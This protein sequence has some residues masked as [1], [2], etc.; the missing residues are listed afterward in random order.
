[1]I[2]AARELSKFFDVKGVKN[3]KIRAVENV[4]I[5]IKEGEIVGLVGESGSGKSTLGRLLIRLIEPTSGEILYNIPDDE[6]DEFDNALKSNDR[7]AI[8]KIANKYSIMRLHGKELKTF[9]RNVGIV[10]QDPYSSLDPRM[11]IE[12][13]IAEPIVE[14]GYLNGEKVKER[15]LE[16][17][18]EVQLPR[19]FSFRYPHELSGGQRQRIALARGIATNPKLVIL[20]EPTSALDVSIQAEILELLKGLRK[21]YNMAMLLITHNISVISYMA[22]RVFV[23][24]AGKIMEKGNKIDIIKNPEHPYTQALIS[25]VPQIK[26]VKAR[27]ILKGDPPNLINPPKG[28]RFHPRCPV[29]L[30]VCGWTADEVKPTL[31]YLIDTK[32]F[33]E[34]SNTKVEVRNE[35]E[36]AVYNA[37]ADKLKEIINVEKE[38]LRPLM[39]IKDVIEENGNVTIKL[40]Q[41][42]TPELIELENG[43]EV[44]CLLFSK[45]QIK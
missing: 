45:P 40:Y 26:R 1:M 38:N 17:L 34:F 18:D 15:V 33:T 11:K 36:L 28:C 29:A 2:I 4:N 30:P 44:E 24:Y 43:R 12:D 39:S 22:D 16:L 42:E 7:N 8:E 32:Y 37:K 10:F 25:A 35:L 21:K 14:T 27:I 19:E 20:D 23:M 9:R 41:Y 6:L 3:A 5:E 13:I 31:D